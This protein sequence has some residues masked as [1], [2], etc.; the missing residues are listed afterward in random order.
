MIFLAFAFISGPASFHLLSSLP[1]SSSLFVYCI[2]ACWCWQYFF[3]SF[4]RFSQRFI[5]FWFYYLDFCHSFR[6]LYL[7]FYPPIRSRSLSISVCCTFFMS[8]KRLPHATVATDCRCDIN[9]NISC[10]AAK[11][12]FPI[13]IL[14]AP[15]QQQ[16]RLQRLCTVRCSGKYRMAATIYERLTASTLIR[17]RE[18]ETRMTAAGSFGEWSGYGRYIEWYIYV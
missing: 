15:Q 11:E 8:L 7:P 6:S 2:D 14:H 17:D 3:N 10:G 16:A 12:L 13:C 5:S 4:C 9:E 18:R 1:S